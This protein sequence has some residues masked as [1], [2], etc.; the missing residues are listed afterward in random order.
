[1]EVFTDKLRPDVVRQ[2]ALWW[3]GH[4]D[5]ANRGENLLPE[6]PP[7]PDVMRK[8][9]CS[10]EEALRGLCLGEHRHFAGVE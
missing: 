8:F 3:Q 1:M 10:E 7:L 2:I 6:S 4:L 5:E 9:G